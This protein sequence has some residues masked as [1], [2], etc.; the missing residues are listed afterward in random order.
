MTRKSPRIFRSHCYQ[1]GNENLTQILYPSRK[2]LHEAK[3]S[4][5]KWN[6]TSR[7]GTKDPLYVYKVEIKEKWT[8]I[9]PQ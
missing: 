5:K 7:F 3:K 1:I 4:S 2:T 6:R 8:K 9:H